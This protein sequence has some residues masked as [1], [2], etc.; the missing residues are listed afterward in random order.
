M[1]CG[2]NALKAGVRFGTRYDCLKK[3]IGV[4]IHAPVDP[5]YN[6][7][8][9][10]IDKTRVYCGT[11]KRLPGNYDRMGS[12]SECL[13]KG[14]GIGKRI[15]AKRSRRPSGKKKSKKKSAKRSKKKKKS[16]KKSKKSRKARNR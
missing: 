12:P 15:S 6:E 14:V 5:S 9:E 3:G 8:Y 2:N 13:R 7:P 16:K 4:G 1:Y 10:P 11:K